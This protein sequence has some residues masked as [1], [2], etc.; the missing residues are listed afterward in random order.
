MSDE[1]T[2]LHA[3]ADAFFASVEQRDD[4]SLRGRP[5][6]VGPGVVM[7]ASY[8]AKAHGIDSGMGWR[9]ARRLC[10]DAVVV[11]PRWAAYVQASKDIFRI[12]EDTAPVVEG[13]SMEEAFL[14]VRGLRRISGT[15]AEIAMRLRRRVRERVGLA[16]TVGVATTK[17]LAKVASGM[18]K[19]DGLMVVEP[20]RELEFLH[21]LPVERIWGVGAATAARLHARGIGSVGQIARL[22]ESGLVSMLGRASGRR[23]HAIAH[24]RDPRPVRR[25]RRRRSVGAQCAMGL[26]RFG[27]QDLDPVLLGLVDRVTRRMRAA[28]VRGRTVTLRFRFGDY[29]RATRSRTMREA[30]AATRT[31]L[32]TARSVLGASMPAIERRGLTLLGVTVANLE[33]GAPQLTLPIERPDEASL[34]AVLDHLRDRF[35]SRSVTRATLLGRGSRFDPSLL[36]QDEPGPGWI[37]APG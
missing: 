12:F 22:G 9:Q 11:P 33:P 26:S 35:G 4:P 17:L 3:D 7:A 29:T 13:I 8:E 15:P 21:S 30:S 25:G 18:A 1:A 2:I 31:V 16:M 19:P 6:V 34:D 14:D 37:G 10:P 32:V 20:A 23:L 5:V 24:N 28:G 27:L 36:P